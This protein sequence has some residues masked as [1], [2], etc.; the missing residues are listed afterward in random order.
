MNVPALV[1][2]QK[3]EDKDAFRKALQA[4]VMALGEAVKLD[5]RVQING[6]EFDVGLENWE[7]T[8]CEWPD[9]Q[10][11]CSI[12]VEPVFHKF[13]SSWLG[14][15]KRDV[16]LLSHHGITINVDHTKTTWQLKPIG[17]SVYGQDRIEHQGGSPKP[18]PE[19]IHP[20]PDYD[21]YY[22]ED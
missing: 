20:E 6:T 13:F 22:E 9:Y 4:L 10:D 1:I 2:P 16:V 19:I 3:G 21:D 12:S 5:G 11:D 17:S 7:V 18:E 14:T 15:Y 8:L